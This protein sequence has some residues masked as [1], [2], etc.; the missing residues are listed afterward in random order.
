[1]TRYI[2]A[3]EGMPTVLP[4]TWLDKG[5]LYLDPEAKIPVTWNFGWANP[6]VGLA[7]DLQRNE[8]TGEV[9]VEIRWF[10]EA[11]TLDKDHYDSTFWATDLE[12]RQ[13]EATDDHSEYRLILKAKV[14]GIAIVPVAAIPRR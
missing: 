7:S 9:S 8:E 10:D 11:F 3:K 2:I 14:R 13:V 5:S 12:E 6:S 1:M 4:D